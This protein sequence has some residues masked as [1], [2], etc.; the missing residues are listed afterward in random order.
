[1][2]DEIQAVYKVFASYPK[3]RDFIACEHCWSDV[4]KR[5]LLKPGLS[6]L[7]PDLLSHYAMD[8]FCTAG[9]VPDFKY[10]LPRI[11]ELSV[12]VNGW[13]PDPEV[14]LSRLRLAE[15]QEWPDNEKETI[16]ALLNEKF[17]TL[18]KDP[19]TKGEDIDTWI[20]AL[21]HCMDDISPYL[22]QLLHE[23]SEDQI[24]SFVA[25]N[26]P[27]LPKGEL[28]NAFWDSGLNEKRLKEWLTSGPVKQLISEKYG[29]KL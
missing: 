17:R 4:E 15:W 8:L 10:F 21:S 3:P 9:D 22:A 26:Y 29:I 25:L 24:L 23:A 28:Y 11:L 18:L 19:D 5:D 27:T 16:L 14:V 12:T 13:W 2:Y 7:N 1:M 20:C 6:E